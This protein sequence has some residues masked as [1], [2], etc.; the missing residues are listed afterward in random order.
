ME[1]L[2]RRIE[3]AQNSADTASKT[4]LEIPPETLPR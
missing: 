1:A 4:A 2:K 3:S